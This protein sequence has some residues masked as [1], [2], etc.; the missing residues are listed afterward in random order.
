MAR[1]ALSI[2]TYN[3]LYGML[4]GSLS[5]RGVGFTINSFADGSAVVTVVVHGA[6]VVV[7]IN[8][9]VVAVYENKDVIGYTVADENVIHEVKTLSQAAG[10]IRRLV[11]EARII[12]NKVL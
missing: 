11:S 9:I 4:R 12:L 3:Q 5:G 8:A 7:N 10:H 2:R 1:T 6:N